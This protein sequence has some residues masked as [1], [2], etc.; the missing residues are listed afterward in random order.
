MNIVEAM[1]TNWQPGFFDDEE[2]FARLL[3][4]GDPL[5]RLKEILDFEMF[6]KDLEAG[7]GEVPRK[8]P[9]GRKRLDAVMMFKILILQRLYNLS[10]EQVEFQITDRHSFSRFVGLRGA[11][12]VPDY[13]SVWRFREH[14]VNSGAVE[15]LFARFATKLE[16][17]GLVT[18]AGLL[19]DATFVEVP[20]QR[21]SKQEN[22]LIKAGEV[23]S[24]WSG[25]PAKRAQKDIDARWTQKN[26]HNY[27]GYKNHVKA[28][29]KHR[30]ILKYVASEAS[31]HDSQKLFDLVEARDAGAMLFGDS[32]YRSEANEQQLQAMKIESHIHEKGTRGH[33]LTALQQRHNRAKSSFRAV[34][35]HIFGFMENSMKLLKVRSIGLARV[36]GVIGLVNLTYN[37][38]RYVQVAA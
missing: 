7:L 22:E 23:P 34:V 26:G 13:S 18:R 36:S 29:W 28:D 25:Q 2:R 38:C 19:I 37:I 33:P 27:F 32:A 31:V 6:R 8:S 11:A 10:D 21:N 20:R 4:L 24:E 5:V 9:A 17:E 16:S 30:F 15:K 1:E 14:L 35:E 12:R 3:A